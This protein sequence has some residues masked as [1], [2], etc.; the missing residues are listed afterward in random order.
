[1]HFSSRVVRCLAFVLALGL[2]PH[3][4]AQTFPVRPIRLVVPFP[5]GG[6]VDAYARIVQSRLGEQLGQPIV[7]ENRGG[8]GGMIGADLVAKAAPDGYT[9][10]VGNVAALAMN[11][12]VYASMPYDP[13]RDFT[14]IMHTVDVNY[15]LVIHPA[16][17]VK[18]VAEL[19]A[20]AK[21]SPG[22]LSYGSAG[23]GSAPH[24][25]TELLKQRAGIDIVHVPYKGGGPMV[26]DLLG[27]QIQLAIGDQANLMPQVKAGKLRVLAVG[28][29]RRSPTYPE[30][31]TIAEAGFA[32]FEAGAWQAIVGP[33]GMPAPIVKRLHEALQRSMEAAD[34]RD[35]LLGAG[36][37]PVAG[38]PED[39]ARHI[40]AEIGKWSKVAKEVGARAD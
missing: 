36:L 4:V 31:P 9:L 32:G 11:V 37:D 35:R 21:A 5:P 40:R 17:P 26:A 22:K 18:T 15:V 24:L 23:A 39:L 30:V 28:S 1:M 38:T 12:G 16:V 3:L 6:A 8:A 29:A 27:G 14:P 34:V 20:H 2:T 25:A 13:L 7:I 19:V 10:L 33:A